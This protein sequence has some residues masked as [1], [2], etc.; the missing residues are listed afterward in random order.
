MYT[1]DID[2][3]IFL[4]ILTSSTNGVNLFNWP[5]ANGRSAWE[6]CFWFR[7]GGISFLLYAGPYAYRGESVYHHKQTQIFSV[8]L[9]KS[10][11]MSGFDIF[12]SH[13]IL[14]LILVPFS[15]A[16]CLPL[17]GITAD[18]LGVSAS[19][20]LFAV[21]LKDQT[22]SRSN[23]TVRPPASCVVR[24][25]QWKAV[26][27]RHF[28]VCR[29]L[30][31]HADKGCFCESQ[32]WAWGWLLAHRRDSNP[33]KSGCGDTKCPGRNKNDLYL[34]IIMCRMDNRHRD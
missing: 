4:S 9:S 34:V 31:V 33:G 23:S 30:D 10:V 29:L 24:P 27:L 22:N 21:S 19:G 5:I 1:L 6:T 25:C 2:I 14:L 28:P 12:I 7:F 18:P 13:L 11:L 15:C 8:S 17:A 3:K 20:W 16:L 26:L 32:A